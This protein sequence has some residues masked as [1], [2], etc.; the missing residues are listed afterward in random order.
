MASTSLICDRNLF[1]R[2]SP[3]EAPLTRPA[4][5][6]NVIFALIFC[7][8]LILNKDYLSGHLVHLLYQCLDQ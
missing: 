2:P 6:T 4:M 7:Q 5:S 8:T 3:L 1:P